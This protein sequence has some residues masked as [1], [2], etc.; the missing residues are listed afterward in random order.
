MPKDEHS[1]S[2]G[3]EPRVDEVNADSIPTGFAEA[4][5]VFNSK[6]YYTAF[7][8]MLPACLFGKDRQGRYIYVND[9]F[10]E[11]CN[12]KNR[13]DIIGKKPSR[14]LSPARAK[15]AEEEDQRIM[16]TGKS[17]INQINH[18]FL[19]TGEDRYFMVSKV[20]VINSKKEVIGLAGMLI[21]ITERKLNEQR[22]E[23]LYQEVE[24][25]N[26]QLEIDLE[27]AKEV[28]T[29]FMT[30]KEADIE[31]KEISIAVE[32]RS[33]NKLGGDLIITKEIS[34][35]V[36]SLLLCDVMGHG[37]RAAL[38]T[39][40][41]RGLH[42]EL[43]SR[44]NKPGEFLTALNNR[45]NELLKSLDYTIFATCS[46]SIF[47]LN[48]KKIN[49]AS[50]GHHKPI[51]IRADNKP[52]Q[53]GSDDILNNPGIGIIPEFEYNSHEQKITSGD[54][55]LFFTDGIW[56]VPL[57]GNSPETN[58][59]LVNHLTKNPKKE[60]KQILQGIISDIL[61]DKSSLPDDICLVHVK[62]G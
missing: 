41:L 16:D 42:D 59:F 9:A 56:E 60:G 10:I 3:N 25:K 24:N 17:I 51:W 55:F 1:G 5:D 27:L 31:N 2:I 54:N 45:Y 44:I 57:V 14:I 30:L 28:Q 4:F 43:V 7:T 52:Y 36:W 39:A 20:P 37:V 29:A 34:K 8:E 50:A 35:G 19:V 13:K 11:I 32:H 38:I 26:K 15:R 62:L 12:I 48:S 6:Y 33:S 46:I 21:D 22:L 23:E 47:D 53:L 61:K 40:L 49:Y 18:D 58:E